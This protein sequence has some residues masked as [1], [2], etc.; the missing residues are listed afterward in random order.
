LN[1]NKPTREQ[2]P[3]HP[4]TFP[5]SIAFTLIELL[6]VIAIIS[7]LASMLLPAL[8]TA[9]RKAQITRCVSNFHQV[10]IAVQLY[11]DDFAGLF[12]WGST[13]DLNQ[14]NLQGM[15]WFVWAGR[16]NGNL[17]NQQQ[18]LFN[19]IDRPLNHYGLGLETVSCPL[20]Q[21]RVDSVPHKLW[22]WVGNSY[23]FNAIGYPGG[24]LAGLVGLRNTAL[25]KPARTVT[26]CDA[27]LVVSNNPT[28]WHRPVVSGN[29]LLA[30]GHVEAH[31]AKSVVKLIW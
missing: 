11:Q 4:R 6:V 21:G 8:A 31:T 14:I 2:S 27:V 29:V 13:N 17:S 23:M 1:P 16:T 30:D 25:T 18:G 28:G 22:E 24:M 12:F 20:D 7:I 15:D 19:R 10:Q 5:N 3:A 9:K 26:F